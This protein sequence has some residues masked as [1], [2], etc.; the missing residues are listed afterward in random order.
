[1]KKL[2]PGQKDQERQGGGWGRVKCSVLIQVLQTDNL[3][4]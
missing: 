1:M 2:K 3:I 4:Q